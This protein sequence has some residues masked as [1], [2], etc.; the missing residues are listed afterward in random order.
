MKVPATFEGLQ[1]CRELYTGGIQTLAT[2]VFT[3]EQAILA[4]EVGCISVSPFVHEL[5][6]G[7]DSTL[8]PD[9]T[10]SFSDTPS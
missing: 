10:A 6:A 1:A 9:M 4:A 7:L 2:T 3:M 8:E 5:K